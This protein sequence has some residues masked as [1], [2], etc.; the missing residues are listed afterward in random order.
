MKK[1]KLRG[2]KS[3]SKWVAQQDKLEVRISGSWI[4]RHTC[5]PHFSKNATLIHKS[6][7]LT[8]LLNRH[9]RPA[10]LSMGSRFLLKHSPLVFARLSVNNDSKLW[11]VPTIAL[12]SLG[13]HLPFPLCHWQVP[14]SRCLSWVRGTQ[15]SSFQSGYTQNTFHGFSWFALRS[16]EENL[17]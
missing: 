16:L 3:Y 17:T 5:K 12:R 4:H 8:L 7:G 6:E 2:W 15:A 10:V 14:L 11:S 1:S 13:T 9:C